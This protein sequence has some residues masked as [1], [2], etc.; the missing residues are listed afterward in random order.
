MS[1]S[2]VPDE[3]RPILYGFLRPRELLRMRYLCSAESKCVTSFLIKTYHSTN[4]LSYVCPW[5]GI[6]WISNE[7]IT[8]DDT[9]YDLDVYNQLYEMTLRL[10]I[11]HHTIVNKPLIRKHLYCDECECLEDPELPW[12]VLGKW[13]N[14]LFYENV[15]FN[16]RWGFIL[17]ET[18]DVFY[19]NQHRIAC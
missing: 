10:A 3:L 19:W 7:N 4:L 5:C 12:F 9:F 6:D 13:V 18:D 2:L 14:H 11:I 1:Y 17:H 16:K 15:L 8:T